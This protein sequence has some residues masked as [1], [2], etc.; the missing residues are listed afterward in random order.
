VST[1]LVLGMSESAWI[2]LLTV[3][4]VVIVAALLIWFFATRQRNP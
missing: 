2:G 1:I 3:T 4:P